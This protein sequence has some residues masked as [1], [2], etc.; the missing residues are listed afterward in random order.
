[1]GGEK[2]HTYIH[3]LVWSLGQSEKG[4]L[5]AKINYTIVGIL[6]KESK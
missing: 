2:T 3:V 1:M 6:M 5:K 4:P